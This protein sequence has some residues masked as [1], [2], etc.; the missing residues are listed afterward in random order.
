MLLIV[1]AS[2][3]ILAVATLVVAFVAYPQQGRAIPRARRLS[4]ALQGLVDR[5]GLD[6][7]EDEAVTG[8]S[9]TELGDRWRGRD[10]RRGG[11][12]VQRGEPAGEPAPRG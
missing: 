8:G 6:P 9:L 12:P 3:A 2:L 7:D 11:L 10:G 4:A 1:L 5:T